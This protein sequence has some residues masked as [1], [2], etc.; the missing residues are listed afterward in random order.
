MEKTE[1]ET[2]NKFEGWI[3]GALTA[4]DP[5]MVEEMIENDTVPL[6]FDYELP[7]YLSGMRNIIIKNKDD[8]LKE[9]TMDSVLLYSKQYRPDL[10]KVINTQ[11]GYIWMS[12]FLKVII[13]VIEN[14][15]LNSH[16]MRQKFFA[17]IKAKKEEKLRHAIPPPP[18]APTPIPPTLTP[19]P[20]PKLKAPP[21]QPD[22]PLKEKAKKSRKLDEI[23]FPPPIQLE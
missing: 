19:P 4:I 16:E 23:D 10:A 7:I 12:R 20:T 13:F 14:V 9:L 2:V 8:I 21:S 22:P 18:P 6:L 3:L 15:E 11:D 1:K 5:D 17:Q